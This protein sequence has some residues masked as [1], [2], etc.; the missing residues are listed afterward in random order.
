[1]R[2]TMTAA[3]AALA[4]AGCGGSSDPDADGD[5]SIS[6]DE[7]AAHV[8]QNKGI[9]KPQPGLYRGTTQLVDLTVSGASEQEAAMLKQ[10]MG[11]EART[12][13]FCLTPEEAEKG[14]EEMA[15]QAQG[16]E[17]SFAKFDVTGGTIDAVMNCSG[18]GQGEAQIALKG[19]GSETKS[20]MTMTMNANA[21]T[22][23]TMTM[24]MRTT[25]ERVGDCPG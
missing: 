23:Q 10:M 22:G 4:L 17:C 20:D 18:Q 1:M 9:I 6:M 8:D 7:A 24:T 2:M 11:G 13:E 3:L 14:F 15:K 25:Q 21:P 5:G 12:T 19:T 16:S